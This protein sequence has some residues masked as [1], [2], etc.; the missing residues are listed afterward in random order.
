MRH[1]IPDGAP[2]SLRHS[3]GVSHPCPS[4]SPLPQPPGW[5]GPAPQHLLRG[6][7]LCPHHAPSED[8]LSFPLSRKVNPASCQGPEAPQSPLPRAWHLALCPSAQSRTGHCL[9]PPPSPPKARGPKGHIMSSRIP[10]R[11][12]A[13]CSMSGAFPGHGSEEIKDSD[14]VTE[15]SGWSP[16]SVAG[17]MR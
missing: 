7:L 13:L 9:P 2:T 16:A 5:T 17:L 8:C 15:Q 11:Q 10:S 12:E 4:Q 6:W 1:Q 3:P 14:A